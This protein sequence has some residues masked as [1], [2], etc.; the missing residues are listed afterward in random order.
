MIVK[1]YTIIGFQCPY[2]GSIEKHELSVFEYSDGSAHDIRC[3]DCGRPVVRLERIGR[4]K[5]KLTIVCV[6]CGEKHSYTLRTGELW[7][8]GVK[9]LN[10]P[11]SGEA[12]LAVGGEKQ[13]DAVLEEEFYDIDYSESGGDM[14]ELARLLGSVGSSVDLLSVIDKLRQLSDEGKIS[15]CCGERFM[16]LQIEEGGLRLCCPVCKRELLMDISTPEA[17]RKLMELDAIY[18][19]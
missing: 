3:T 13:V 16:Q 7:A 15:C 6:E 10:C 19:T 14:D 9:V 11:E 5:Y 17:V 1:N 8:Y 2:C 4:N 12:A 18:L